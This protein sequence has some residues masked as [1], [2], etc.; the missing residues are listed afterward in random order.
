MNH[1]PLAQPPDDPENSIGSGPFDRLAELVIERLALSLDVAA[2]KYLK[3]GPID[4]PV[5]E[6]E[7]LRSAARALNA[8]G[9]NRRIGIEFFG[10]QIE[11]SKVIQRG[12]FHRWYA[13]PDEIP[14][15]HGSLAAEVRPKLDRVT[16]QIV[17]QLGCLDEMPRLQQHDW[18][19]LVGRRV[20]TTTPGR[21]LPGLH[22]HATAFALRSF[23]ADF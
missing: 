4:D 10:D 18:A 1:P 2:A 14:D 8:S 11:A 3:G 5:R 13:H 7:V 16:G 12:L 6:Q 15:G 9:L 19:G 21:Q 23:C 22:R 17:R 20:F